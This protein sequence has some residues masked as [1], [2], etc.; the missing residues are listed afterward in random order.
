M[1]HDLVRLAH[2]GSNPDMLRR[3]VAES[4]WSG[5]VRRLRSSSKTSAAVKA[6]L[7]IDTE[8]RLEH[9]S[10]IG[11]E[12]IADGDDRY[13]PALSGLP[14]RPLW[15][16]LRGRIPSAVGVAVVGSRRGTRYGLELARAFGSQI[17]GAG[18]PVISGLAAGVDTAAHSGAV[19]VGGDTMAVLGSG[20]DVWYPRRNRVLGEAILAGGG[21]VIS[22]F[23]PGTTPDS[24]RFP[25][26]NRII[27]GLAGVVIVVEAAVRSGALIT[28]RLAL[29]HGR[30]VMAVP[31][32]L[33]R[34]T[35]VGA[36]LL[37]RD[38]AHPLTELH[39]LIEELELVMGQAPATRLPQG[40]SD[41]DHES[42][43]GLLGPIS[44][45]IDELAV[46]AGV[47]IDRLLAD[48]AHLELSGLVMVEGGSVRS[49]M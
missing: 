16:F 31:G 23:P 10:G 48:L 37:I 45:P 46:S 18:W 19:D 26:R 25:A 35:S 33:S 38:G 20:I 17:A 28:A 15:L 40:G 7:D 24:W 3:L 4:G 9:L 41:G 13:P 34:E 6:G 42:L 14:D 12:L 44:I 43:L 47:S 27:S 1:N 49:C 2:T 22:E 39:A 11:V 5:A 36:N 30:S 29:E 32:D 21:A 8:A